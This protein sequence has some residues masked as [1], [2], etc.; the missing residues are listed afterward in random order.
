MKDWFSY[1]GIV[2]ISGSRDAIRQAFA[3]EL[4]AD[5]EGWMDMVRNRNRTAYTY[6]ESVAREVEALI[7]ERYYPLLLDFLAVM[8]RR[9]NT[10]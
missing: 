6:N 9:E 8:T 2:G 5:G 10:E 3:A 4:L 1:Q 7:A